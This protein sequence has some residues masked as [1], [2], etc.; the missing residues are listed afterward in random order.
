M[1]AYVNAQ[2]ATKHLR[3]NDKCKF[4]NI[5]T[6]SNIFSTSSLDVDSWETKYELDGSCNDIYRGKREMKRTD[7]HKYLGF[8]ISSNGTNLANI[9]S[10]QNKSANII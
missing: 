9:L 7:E 10:K 5:G 1:N 6:D 2:S 4:M 8:V 3:F